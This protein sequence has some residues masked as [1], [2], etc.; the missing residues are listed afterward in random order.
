MP[1]ISRTVW[2]LSIV[3][4][5]ADIASEMLYPIVPIY[6]KHIGFSVAWIG[7]LEGLA[8]L[9]VG[10]SKGYFGRKSD[11]IGLRLPFVK[12]GYALSTIGKSMLPLFQWSSWIFA[13]R[14]LDRLGKGVRTAARDALLSAE[15]TIATKG[16]VFGF[17]RSLDTIGAVI[18]PIIALIF[19]QLHPDA[20]KQLFYYAL[21]PGLL[22][23]AVIYM[24]RE[25]RLTPIT[26]S[27]HLFSY[28][29]YWKRANG[30]YRLLL[31]GLILFAL[32]NSADVFLLLRA[33]EITNSDA[34]TIIGY[35][36]YN[37]SYASFAYLAGKLSDR[38]GSRKTYMLGLCM[39]AITYGGFAFASTTVHVYLLFGI[40]GLFA[41]TTEGVA[42][43]WISNQTHTSEMATGIGFFTSIQSIAGLLASIIAGLLWT[44]FGAMSVF[45]FSAIGAM[46]SLCYFLLIG[47]KMQES[48]SN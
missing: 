47:K 44:N 7:L 16:Q 21:I 43:A 29:H 19:L 42:K 3:S 15:A 35:I 20:Y 31:V 1:V 5:L 22:S 37:I 8:E 46:I 30:H 9:V 27:G 4:L 2:V 38:W 13:A 33:K 26:Q 14:L 24:L 41:A 34:H 6:L 45:A 48:V 28:L 18:G 39:F 36:I 12:W 11:E 25:K 17:H 10:Y 32:I 23:I 40:Y